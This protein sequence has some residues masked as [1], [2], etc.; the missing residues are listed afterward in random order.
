MIGHKENP[1]TQLKEEL[2]L[3]KHAMVGIGTIL[4]HVASFCW[5]RSNV[6]N[7]KRKKLKQSSFKE[8][9]KPSSFKRIVAWS[10]LNTG[11]WEKMLGA[12]E[13]WVSEDQTRGGDLEYF[14][15]NTG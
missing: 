7:N 5:H 15:D 6:Q 14:D 10:R 12:A 2:A 11:E 8:S 3:L 9:Q 13:E 1:T 4:G